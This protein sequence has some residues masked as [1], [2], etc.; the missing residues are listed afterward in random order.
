MVKMGS[1]LR[2]VWKNYSWSTTGRLAEVKT[3][4]RLVLGPSLHVAKVPCLRIDD[5]TRHNDNDHDGGSGNSNSRYPSGSGQQNQTTA[6][7]FYQQQ[8]NSSVVVSVSP[9]HSECRD[10]SK[11]RLV[12][13]NTVA[14]LLDETTPTLRCHHRWW[15][16]RGLHPRT[17]APRR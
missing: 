7:P 3:V 11:I 6:L 10:A 15:G 5:S 17:I 2:D 1:D 12:V 14:T 8:W 4:R 16:C 9:Q 13:A